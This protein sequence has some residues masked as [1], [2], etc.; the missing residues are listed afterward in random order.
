MW[1]HA[2]FV[3]HH[4]LKAWIFIYRQTKDVGNLFAAIRLFD[5]FV[6]REPI[7]DWHMASM[8]RF[9]AQGMA[10]SGPLIT[11]DVSKP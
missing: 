11:G 10:V 5:D 9:W 8:E 3:M 6:E 2:V 1:D 7:E 4:W